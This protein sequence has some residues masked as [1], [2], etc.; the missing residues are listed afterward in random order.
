MNEAKI[1]DTTK[2]PVSNIKYKNHNH[3]LDILLFLTL[4]FVIITNCILSW[5]IILNNSRNIDKIKTEQEYIYIE[6]GSKVYRTEVSDWIKE[7][8]KKNPTLIIPDL[9]KNEKNRNSSE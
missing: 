4:S 3:T 5:P 8:K 9:H 2:V 6:S 1:Y 7:V